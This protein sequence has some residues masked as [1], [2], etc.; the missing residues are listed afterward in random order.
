L[1][2][3]IE[4]LGN[5]IERRWTQLG[6][7]PDASE[8]KVLDL[9]Q[10]VAGVP[11][12]L[13]VAADGAR[14]LVPF[15]KDKHR[16]FR[17]ETRS[18]GV[19]LLVRQLEQQDGNRW[20]LDVVCTRNELRWLF[21][22]FVADILLR[23]RRHPDTDPPAIVRTCF[24]AWRALFA[25]AERRLSVKQLA[26]L[27]GELDVLSRL[28]DRSATAIELWKGPL[29]DP[30]DFVSPGL[31]VEVKTTLS[32]EDDIVHIHG[33]EQL[34]APAEGRLHLAH[35]RVEVPSVDGESVPDLVDRLREVD[36]SGKLA[37]LLEAGG[38]HEE[39]RSTYAD[40]GFKVV[41][42]RWFEVGAE[43]PRLS[44]ESFPDGHVPNGLSD[45]RY[46]LDLST[47]TTLPLRDATVETLLD[48]M[49]S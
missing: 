7:T 42:E 43:F 5:E 29:R 44:A 9:P 24:T 8:M 49:S 6:E 39:H 27:F 10:S 28:L 31:D 16:S 46:T 35:L 14:M 20:F 21:S 23:L 47:V 22:S 40:L 26:G 30:H 12:Y 25:G 37:A 4:D 13:G 41:D 38:Y 34:S 48:S 11:V 17:P 15:E 36:S 32:N 18:R 45:F 33:L 1:T 19:H 3:T 2:R